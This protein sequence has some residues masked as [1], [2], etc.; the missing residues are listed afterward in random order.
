MLTVARGLLSD[1]VVSLMPKGRGTASG[2]GPWEISL[3]VDNC[4]RGLTS[5]VSTYIAASPAGKFEYELD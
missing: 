5:L 2:F 1:V 4:S 3:G